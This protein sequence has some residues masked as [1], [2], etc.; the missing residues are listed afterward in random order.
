[1]NPNLGLQEALV[2]AM[3]AEL[4]A[5][6]FYA[7]AALQ[8]QDPQGQDLLGRLAAFEQYHYEKLTELARSLQ[9]Q[10][11]F[12]EYETRAIEEFHPL[13]G[14]GEAAGTLLV[15]MADPTGILSTAI[16]NEKKAGERYRALS[17]ETTDPRGQAM[18]RD[19]ANEE[20]IHQR[21]LEDEFFTLSNQGVW[22]WAGMYGE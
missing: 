14:G 9:E 16:E 13:T 2:M 17:A 20:M 4:A 22:A 18:F 6:R 3:E 10:G 21:I 11:Q 5:R 1:M 15:E 12:I 8:V 19:L 7:Q